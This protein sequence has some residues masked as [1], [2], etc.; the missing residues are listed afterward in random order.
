MH[1][2]RL[3]DEHTGNVDN[4]VILH[5]RVSS[6]IGYNFACAVY[7]GHKCLFY[8]TPNDLFFHSQCI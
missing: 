8:F 2:E 6:Y 3:R 4:F 1:F 7:R 5:F